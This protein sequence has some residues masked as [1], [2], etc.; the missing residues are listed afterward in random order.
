MPASRRC[1]LALFAVLVC[2]PMAYAQVT[3]PD[4][5]F[6]EA[7]REQGHFDLALEFLD[8]AASDSAVSELF[9]KRIAYERAATGLEQAKTLANNA[10]REEAI[11]EARRAFESF[12]KGT[13]DVALAAEG[14]GRLAAALADQ[15][16]RL[17]AQ[18]DQRSSKSEQNELLREARQ[19]YDDARELYQE[20]AEAYGKALDAYQSV[21]PGSPEARE[22]LNLKLQFA[23]VGV[24]GS[25]TLYDKAK[26]YPAGSKTFKQLN[27][28][29]AE[30]LVEYAD[31]YY[32][33]PIGMYASL[34]EGWCYQANG[35][36]K[37]ALGCFEELILA[38]PTVPAFRE[39]ITLAHVYLALS[40]IEEKLYEKAYEDG[41]AWLDELRRGEAAAAAAALKYQVG[42]AARLMA[43][44][45]AGGDSRRLLVKAQELLREAGRVPTEFQANAR[46]KLA[47]VNEKLG[48]TDQPLATFAD[49][50][51]AGRDA[52]NAMRA[53]QTASKIAQDNNPGDAQGFQTQ[54]SEAQRE[55]RQA[56][57][58]ALSLVDDETEQSQVNEVRHFLSWLYWEEGDYLRA[59]A[60]GEFIATT[61]ADDPTA[62]SAA[63]LALASLER[64]YND[65]VQANEDAEFE[66]AHLAHVAE[67][68]IGR[69]GGGPTADAALT[70]LMNLALRSGNLDDARRV[71]EQAP[72]EE[73]AALE[74]R[75]AS[76][77]WERAVRLSASAGDDPQA[78]LAA[79]Q[80]KENA[81]KLLEESYRKQAKAEVTTAS[82]TAGLYL[83]QALIDQGDSAAALKLL[84]D[85]TA[86]PLTLVNKKAP[87]V[88]RPGYAAEAY[89]VALRAYVS[90]SPPQTDRALQVMDQLE[91]AVG[92]GSSLTRVYFGLGL[93][94][95]QQIA[96]LTARAKTAQAQKISAAFAVFLDRL[97][98][99]AGDSDWVTQQ[100][101][102]Q[103]YL[104]LGDG[105]AGGGDEAT[106]QE[107]YSQAVETFQG[108]ID[109]AASDPSFPPSAN[110]VL[111]ARMQLGQAQRQRGD[112]NAAID[113]FSSILAERPVMLD[114]QKAAAS[115]YQQWGEEDPEQL[116]TAIRGARPDA[117]DG[118]N[119]IW[120]WSKLASIAARA[121]RSRP[122]YKD[123]FFEC[124][125]NVA[126]CRTLAG[127][128]ASG[129]ARDKQLASAKRTIKSMVRQYPD[130]GG[131]ERWSQ[132]NRLM[133]Q[134]QQLEGE[135]PIGLEALET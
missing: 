23:G 49:A 69:W 35:D 70:I 96:D 113:T 26:A 46:A 45:D 134:I 80:A 107:Y 12:V 71:V 85:K 87:A 111:A 122:E 127:E 66:A 118:K 131:P 16:R 101:I 94:L 86:G 9:K 120:G 38:D 8:A 7:L 27:S 125:L 103:T 64:L 63:K 10:A 24:M 58:Q 78:R 133:K 4:I 97:A 44:A 56:F 50:Y 47:V 75:L 77:M 129:T 93:Q 22:R 13:S 15:G 88:D 34:Y 90:V 126:T 53:A 30:E 115:T 2:H 62:E 5:R 135:D 61:Q 43:D 73:R 76:A 52:L 108:M 109:R 33:Q 42:E 3:D 36:H 18:G 67:F 74:L 1:A 11:A 19:S 25:R 114:V 117:K 132:Y 37:L 14:S 6:V 40:R 55:A 130:L 91:K 57:S 60:L 79:Q 106:R 31:K 100:W 28:E 51:Q 92:G 17:I 116:L 65:A 59:A 20:A 119:L 39:I 124:W 95:Q 82:A 68:A 29:A 89:K 48:A 32:D 83:A 123:L 110:S 105:L 84:E 112:F 81:A 98:E 102:G 99:K 54:A 121:A 21:K 104:S 41:L 72:A 128:K